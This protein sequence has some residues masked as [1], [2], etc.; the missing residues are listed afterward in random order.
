[1]GV[2]GWSEIGDAC[3]ELAQRGDGDPSLCCKVSEG[4]SRLLADLS[5]C[6]SC[7]WFGWRGSGQADSIAA[8]LVI[9]MVLPVVSC[10]VNV[11]HDQFPFG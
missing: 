10:L 11:P 5:Q 1:V 8:T 9:S 4:D 2:G 6:D 7:R 3:L